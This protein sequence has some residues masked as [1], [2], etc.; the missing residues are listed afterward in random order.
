MKENGYN[1][2]RKSFK[3]SISSIGKCL[4]KE[5]FFGIKKK[6]KIKISESIFK[7]HEY[8]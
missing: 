7:S 8:T 3:F 1:Y 6:I 5:R 2:Q 4:K